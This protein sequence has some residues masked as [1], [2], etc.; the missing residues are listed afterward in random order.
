ME[1]LPEPA[2]FT[3][4]LLLNYDEL[5]AFEKSNSN[6]I[7]TKIMNN[8]YFWKVKL[9]QEYDYNPNNNYKKTYHLISNDGYNVDKLCKLGKIKP[10]CT[11]GFWMA[12]INHDFYP[13]HF[14]TLL[15]KNDMY[16]WINHTANIT[17]KFIGASIKINSYISITID[18]GNGV[19]INYDD[20]SKLLSFTLPTYQG[21]SD[22]VTYALNLNYMNNTVTYVVIDFDADQDYVTKF[23]TTYDIMYNILFKIVY[24]H[25]NVEILNNES[26]E[27]FPNQTSLIANI[28]H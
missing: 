10:L 28:N 1:L 20:I 5:I 24:Y 13:A 19:S 14:D 7:V 17:Q 12:K 26:E 11:E 2:L 6:K 27:F 4:M 22:A 16:A 15:I 23:S 9:E 8:E 18:N 21:L 3:I 25:P